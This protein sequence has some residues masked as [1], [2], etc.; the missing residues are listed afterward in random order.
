[1][2]NLVAEKNDLS[3][4][5]LHHS[6][7]RDQDDEVSNTSNQVF[8]GDGKSSQTFTFISKTILFIPSDSLLHNMKGKEV[9][10]FICISTI[11]RKMG[12]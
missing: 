8:H 12:I 7:P 2:E 4:S 10:V 11:A 3:L 1:M 5:F 6:L 9:W